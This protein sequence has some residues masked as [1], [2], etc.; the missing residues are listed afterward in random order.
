M[1]PN[2]RPLDRLDPLIAFE[3]AARRLSFAH[4]AEELRITPSAISQRIRNLEDNLGCTLFERGHRSIRLT[5]EGREFHNSVSVA[6]SHLMNAATELKAHRV[7]DTMHVATDTSVAALWLAPR[8][9]RFRNIYPDLSIRLTVSDD[10]AVLLRSDTDIAIIHG[11]GNWRGFQAEP[12]FDEVVFPVCSPGYLESLQHPAMT[13]S[14][15]E[16]TVPDLLHGAH[17]LD[18]EFERWHWMNWPIWLTEMGQEL[19]QRPRTLRTNNYPFLIES[20]KRRAGNCAGM[21]LHCR[22]CV[23]RGHAC[24]SGQR[25]RQNATGLSYCNAARHFSSRPRCCP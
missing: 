11:D 16:A 7:A 21:A 23:G 8:L 10:P 12:L 13:T 18:L 15:D 24:L 1:Q 22:R 6:L 9:H 17:L 20:A 25:T 19:P 2:R 14:N 3:A 5:D 4:A